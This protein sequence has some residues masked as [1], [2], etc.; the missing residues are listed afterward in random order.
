MC[1]L[2]LLVSP[3]HTVRDILRFPSIVCYLYLELVS[4]DFKVD[5][6]FLPSLCFTSL[7]VHIL[8][9]LSQEGTIRISPI[10]VSPIPPGILDCRVTYRPEC[11]E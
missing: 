7:V 2:S 10:D 4:K 9:H 8:V 5:H 1:V 3:F 6:H 11:T